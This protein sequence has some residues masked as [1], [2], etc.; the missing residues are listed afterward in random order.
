MSAIK[1]IVESAKYQ[2]TISET[3]DAIL[4]REF[5]YC[6]PVGRQLASGDFVGVLTF[7]TNWLRN[8]VERIAVQYALN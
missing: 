7:D 8:I 5:K 6:R 1:Q 3:V 2:P 4:A